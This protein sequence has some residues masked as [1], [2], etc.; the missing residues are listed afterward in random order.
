VKSL[1]EVGCITILIIPRSRNNEEGEVPCETVFTQ[2]FSNRIEIPQNPDLTKDVNKVLE[3]VKN[4][5]NQLQYREEEK[6]AENEISIPKSNFSPTHNQLIREEI[7]LKFIFKDS[8]PEINDIVNVW[9]NDQSRYYTGRVIEVLGNCK[10]NLEHTSNKKKFNDN[11]VNLDLKN[12]TDDVQAEERW[13][14]I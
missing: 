5:T 1:T 9:Y 10:Y 8:P 14:F 3:E 7:K 2:V 12:Q 4:S 13:Q 11:P 6:V